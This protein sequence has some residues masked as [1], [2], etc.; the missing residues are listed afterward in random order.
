MPLFAIELTVH[1]NHREKIVDYVR[2]ILFS[3]FTCIS[4]PKAIE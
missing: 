2:V 4:E 3:S 1:T